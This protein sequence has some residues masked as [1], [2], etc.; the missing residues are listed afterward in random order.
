M[1]A[2]FRN[3][4]TWAGSADRHV[5]LTSFHLVDLNQSFWNLTVQYKRLRTRCEM[6]CKRRCTRGGNV[7]AAYG[8][9]RCCAAHCLVGSRFVETVHFRSQLLG[10]ISI[11]DQR[12]NVHPYA[13]AGRFSSRT[14]LIVF[15]HA[16]NA[17][18]NSGR[19]R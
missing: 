4:P 3:P 6:C 8:A 19:G 11:G 14:S 13:F 15:E 10:A 1:A 16:I 7:L 9:C 5:A 2:T 12:Q 18:K 17:F